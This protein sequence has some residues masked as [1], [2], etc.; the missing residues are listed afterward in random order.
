MALVPDISNADYHSRTALSQSTA[1]LLE[2]KTPMHV[3]HELD[4]PKPDDFAPYL[5]GGCTH[6]AVLEPGKLQEEYD[7]LPDEIDGKSSRTAYYKEAVKELKASRPGVRWMKKA[8]YDLSLTMADALLGNKFLSERLADVDNLVEHSGFFSYEGAECKLRPDLFCPEEKL[9]IDLKTTAGE[10][11]PRGFSSS[12]KRYGYAFQA[13]WYLEG[14][15]SLGIPATSFV[16][17]VVEK[18][19]PHAVGVYRLSG[20]D[21]RAELPRVQSACRTWAMC[22]SADVWPGYSSECVELD[23]HPFSDKRRL[24]LREI[25]EQ[26]GATPYLANQV[27]EEYRLDVKWIGNRKTVDAGDFQNAWRGFQAGKNRSEEAA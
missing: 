3:R 22:S 13:A 14:L 7:C 1:K 20:S 17:V 26:F 25:Q 21:I 23:L 18:A 9:V 8:D 10:A 19:P 2:T 4:N 12:V 11:S 27:M 24:S 5:V 16:F 6:T 15:R